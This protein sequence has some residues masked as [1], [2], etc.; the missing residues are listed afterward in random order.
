MSLISRIRC[1]FLGLLLGL[2]LLSAA[3]QLSLYPLHM[4]SHLFAQNVS[5][6]QARLFLLLLPNPHSLRPSHFAIPTHYLRPAIVRPFLARRRS[7]LGLDRVVA[8]AAAGV[9]DMKWVMTMAIV[10]CRVLNFWAYNTNY[11]SVRPLLLA[12]MRQR[13]RHRLTNERPYLHRMC[14]IYAKQT[15]NS[16]FFQI[17][18]LAQE[19]TGLPEGETMQV[20]RR[21]CGK[22]GEYQLIQWLYIVNIYLSYTFLKHKKNMMK[23]KL[24]E[25]AK[26]ILYG[27]ILKKFIG[28]GIFSKKEIGFL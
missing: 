3:R 28:A 13:Q 14:L 21:I 8:V 18:R 9:D 6:F 7:L 10:K 25:S 1:C 27:A 19:V 26:V 22:I 5:V 17:P 4:R 20:F 11:T 12:A 24:L 16:A 2:L 15:T 23:T